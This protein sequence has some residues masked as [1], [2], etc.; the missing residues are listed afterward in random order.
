MASAYLGQMRFLHL[1]MLRENLLAAPK[2]LDHLL[3]LISCHK[4]Y[5]NRE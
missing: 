3:N 2:R 1:T 5:H 4:K